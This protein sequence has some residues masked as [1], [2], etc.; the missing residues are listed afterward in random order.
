MPKRF[1]PGNDALVENGTRRAPLGTRLGVTATAKQPALL[2]LDAGAGAL[3]GLLR[4]VGGFL[5][6]LLQDGLGRAVD[7]ILGLLEAEARERAHLFDHL[8]LLVAG[9]G[10]DDV[11]LVLLLGS[12]LAATPAAGS[13]HHDG[14]RGGRR[15]VERLLELLDEL[16]QLEQRHLLELLQQV[17]RRHLRHRYSSS[18]EAA[19][20]GVSSIAAASGVSAASASGEW[21]G[22]AESAEADPALPSPA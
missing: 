10:E 1:G 4:G 18:S 8:D 17:V 19:A 2:H 14:R 22:A 13:G 11:E 6:H 16:R 20:S 7:Q 9:T 12:G 21:S 15:H 5:G 3:E